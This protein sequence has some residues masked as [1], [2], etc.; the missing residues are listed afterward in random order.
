MKILYAIEAMDNFGV[1]Q[2]VKELVEHM[3]VNDIQCHIVTLSSATNS[4][5]QTTSISSFEWTLRPNTV[6]RMFRWHP[7]MRSELKTLIKEKKPDIVHIHGI[8]TPFQREV[9]MAAQS[10]NVQIL[11][12]PH[13]MLSDWLWAKNNFFF[14]I[15]KRLYWTLLIQP[16]FKQVNYLHAI[17][18][19][20]DSLLKKQYPL[21]PRILISNAISMDRARDDSK[22][23]H[24][25]KKFVF[26]GRLHPVK[27]VEMLLKAFSNAKLAE[28]WRL[29]I[30]GP[31]FDPTY[32]KYLK[33]LAKELNIVSQAY[34][35]GPVYGERKYFFLESAWAVVVPSHSEVVSL[36]NLEASMMQ[37]PT[38]T[39]RA[40]GLHN[41]SESGGILIEN[42]V[43]ALIQALEDVSN[44]TLDERRHRGKIARDFVHQHHSWQ[45]VSEQWILAYKKICQQIT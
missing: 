25:E 32:T 43:N 44:W 17:T 7:N 35:V 20:E 26:L 5:K 12:S 24:I 22:H 28:Y 42:K 27:G 8:M 18:S 34:F 30:I 37:T 19:L 11:L 14:K 1:A 38:I 40:T 41:W 10:F 6:S 16:A 23:N 4:E 15:F 2:I 29:E 3:T 31:D 39:T 13:G 9:I 36:V 21:I 45:F 33:E